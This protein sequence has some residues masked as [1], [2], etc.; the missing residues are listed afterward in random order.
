MLKRLRVKVPTLAPVCILTVFIQV[1]AINALGTPE[2]IR[3][4]GLVEEPLSF[5]YA[6]L[7]SFPMVHEIA[8]MECVDHSLEVIFNWTGVPLFHLLTLAQVEP[9][10]YDVVFRAT[11]GYSSS[12]T[13]QEA[14]KPTT[15]LALKANGTLLSEISGREGGFRIV[16]PCKWG[17][18][19]VRDVEEIE[20][21]DYDHKGRW[22]QFL[23]DEADMPNCTYPKITPSLQTFDVSF[24]KRT[25]QIE[26]FTNV[27]IT[28][29][30]F[31]H[32]QKEMSFNLTIPT[33]TT[34]FA[35][36]IIQQE[37]LKGPYTIFLDEEP[38]ES[39]EANV[40]ELTLLYL[41]FPEGSHTIKI[42]GT[43]FYGTAPEIIVEFN[44]TASVAE[45]IIFDASKSID[46]GEIV[47]YEWNFGDGT[48]DSKA[49]TSH[50]YSKEGSYQVVLRVTDSEGFSNLKTL[51]V[52]VEEQ[53]EYVT[54]LAIVLAAIIGVLAMIFIILLLRRKTK[55]GNEADK[56]FDESSP[57]FST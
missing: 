1:F 15:I 19:W 18:K 7:L 56:A 42:V 20:V 54:V 55:A 36:F 25:F 4:V 10:A 30:S 45:P 5:T 16:V 9:E 31:N 37:L 39:A 12:I 32:S 17:Y 22:E 29:F 52:T 49:I 34:G 6:E 11:D 35:D 27:S 33:E 24:G 13:I 57:S 23:S 3:I 21:V 28:T 26:A 50:S 38:V 53:P 44:Q 43:E 48:N 46:D 51:T 47:S 41:T 14:L 2:S 8:T 40:N